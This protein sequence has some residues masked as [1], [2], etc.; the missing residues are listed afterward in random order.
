MTG[1]TEPVP[2]PAAQVDLPVA[3]VV[4]DVPLAHL[5]R[6]FDYLVPAALDDIAQPGVRVRVRFAG[7]QVGGFVTERLASSEHQGRLSAIAKV[8]SPEPVLSPAILE[9]ARAVSARYAGTVSDV[10]RLAIPPRHAR[11]EAQPTARAPAPPPAVPPAGPWD[12]YDEGPGLLAA[13]SAGRSPRAVWSALPGPDWPDA[14]ALAVTATLASGRGALVVLPDGR[15]VARVDDAL[16]ARL[17]GERHVVLSADLGPAERYRRW[18]AVRRGSARAVVGT[19]AAMFA[20]VHDLGLVAVWDDGDDLH[21]E[22]HAPYPHVREVL[23]LRALGEGCGLLV[24]GFARTAEA[25]QLVSTGWARPVQANRSV[26][27]GAAPRVLV[28]GDDA[29]QAADPAA[30]T[31]RLPSLAW[32]TAR[33]AL[34]RGPV[35]VQVPRGGYLPSMAC[36]DCRTPARCP[37]CQGPLATTA[38]QGTPAC[39]WCGHPAVGWECAVCGGARTRAL[40]V[41]ARRTAEELGRAFPQVPVRTSGRDG[42]LAGVGPE[43][44]LVIATPGAE[45]VAAGEG[46]AAALLLDGWALLTRPDLR[47]GEEALR[48]WLAAAALVRP[49]AE[50]GLVVVLADPASR[51]VQAL[52]RW[53]PEGFAERELADRLVS[54]LPPAARMA[55]LTGARPALA[56][57]LEITELPPGAEVLGP[58]AAPGR[59]TDEGPLER[60]IVRVP[61]TGGRAL[62]EALHAAA[63]VRS[64]RKEAGSV[65]VQVDPLQIA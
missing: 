54:R 57:L 12:S 23:G 4:L 3:R 18:L 33:D 16:T 43:P 50:G 42:V 51:A 6:P 31:A 25:A 64:A 36:A 11:V 10:L 47:A 14:L 15:D 37:A 46:Y 13:L 32:R 61:R 21:S 49:A 24:G 5:D 58:V 48:R 34:T 35:L 17:G 1:V 26:L 38:N 63:G 22:P 65:R 56:R 53:D 55:S 59:D 41:G 62:A 27:R 30:R 45:P 29:E 60:M 19:R 7:R 44:A 8:V 40:V 52:V 9:L 2:D 20:P 28:A 39:A